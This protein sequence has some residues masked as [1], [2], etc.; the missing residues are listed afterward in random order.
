MLHKIGRRRTLTNDMEDF[1]MPYQ[2]YVTE[3]LNLM[4]EKYQKLRKVS[5]PYHQRLGQFK[6][7][8]GYR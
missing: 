1:E 7:G 4:I 6:K 8:L 3:D 5:L 2:I